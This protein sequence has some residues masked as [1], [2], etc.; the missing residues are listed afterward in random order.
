MFSGIMDLNGGMFG[1]G[2][3]LSPGSDGSMFWMPP[4]GSISAT[5]YWMTAMTAY[6]D[7]A[8]TALWNTAMSEEV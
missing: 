8:M 6:W 5:S 1:D 7:T 3:V 2:Q 4:G